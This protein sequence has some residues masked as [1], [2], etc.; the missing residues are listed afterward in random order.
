MTEFA[1]EIEARAV[2]IETVAAAESMRSFVCD[3]LRLGDVALRWFR[4]ATPAEK[5]AAATTLPAGMFETTPEALGKTTP[6]A[7]WLRA[8]LPPLIAAETVAHMLRHV[9]IG[10]ELGR[11]QPVA[12][13]SDVALEDDARRYSIRALAAWPELGRYASGANKLRI[14]HFAAELERRGP[15]GGLTQ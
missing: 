5:A 2:A 1:V 12:T 10:R 8:T 9:S 7:V 15:E 11:V 4:A 3:D 6:G 14:Q 13:S